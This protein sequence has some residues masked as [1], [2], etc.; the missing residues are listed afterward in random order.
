MRRLA[1]FAVAAVVAGCS[2][3]GSLTI[4]T[5]PPG[6]LLTDP[7]G[8]QAVSPATWQY[9]L[10]ERL[11]QA[12]GCFYVDPIT[13][14]WASGFEVPM[15]GP[16][17]LCGRQGR[18]W[19]INIVRPREAPGLEQDIAAGQVHAQRMQAADQAH[20]DAM[21]RILLMGLSGAAQGYGDAQQ[22]NA[23]RARERERDQYLLD[24]MRREQRQKTYTC[25]PSYGNNYTCR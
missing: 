18:A 16:I 9:D 11:R 6:A 2:T 14:K 8:H 15:S 22:E 1:V 10:P 19:H 5:D 23:R 12:N 7:V 25:T 17:P 3:A 13:T 4:H 21:S 20:T 24:E